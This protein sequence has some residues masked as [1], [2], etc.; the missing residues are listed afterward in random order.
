MQTQLS[1]WEKDRY[2]SSID[3]VIAGSGIVGLNSALY[4][5]KKNPSLNI[6]VAERGAL[7]SGASTK[8]AGFAC[9]GSPSE[10]IDDLARMPE[11]DVFSLVEKRFLGLQRLRENIGDEAMRFENFGGYEVF[12]NDET[13]KECEDH[14]TYF[15]SRLKKI[16]AQEKSFLIADEK[17]RE[18]GL[19]NVK[20]L[21]RI[22]AEGQIDTGRMMEALIA[23]VKSL[24]VKIINGIGIKRFETDEKGV[25]LHTD[26]EYDIRA[27]RF[28]ICVNGFAKKLL[29]AEDVEPAR[30]QVLIT[31]PVHGLKLKGTF[32]YDKGYY[33]F[34]N[35][36]DRVL[37]GGGRN[38][39]F[40]GENTTDHALT[41]QI[42]NRLD[43]VLKT[44]ILPGIDFKVD[45]R[46]SGTMGIGA[47]KNPIVKK[48]SDHVYCAVRMG[49]M[50]VAL[51][52][53]TGEEAADLVLKEM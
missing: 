48:I 46:W 22:P 18:F 52:S 37:F 32:H 9:F 35:V 27:K 15:N 21:I 33:Y 11:E 28:L 8:N 25:L 3:I 12:T 2:Y 16:T 50:G 7:P 36:N 38:L 17:I 41:A 26:Q 14:L 6:L 24:G 10:L 20:H 49:G 31:H 4:L 42:Q 13:Y 34:R 44:M 29:P 53:L 5:K 1:F 45:L 47:K 19:G 30:A 51:G 43:E 40:T 23:K 39:D